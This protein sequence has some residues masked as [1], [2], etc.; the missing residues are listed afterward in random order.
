MPST[1]L[2]TRRVTRDGASLLHHAD[3]RYKVAGQFRRGK[4]RTRELKAAMMTARDDALGTAPEEYGQHEYVRFASWASAT[5][6]TGQIPLYSTSWDNHASRAVARELGLVQY[7][8]DL[9]L[10]QPRRARIRLSLHR[11]RE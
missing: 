6:A 2:R 5:R 3:P 11:A 4:A 1:A 8:A 9:S 7:A 10:W